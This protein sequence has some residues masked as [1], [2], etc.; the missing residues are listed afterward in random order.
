MKRFASTR[1]EK[2]ASQ[3]SAGPRAVQRR[4]HR[5]RRDPVRVHDPRLDREHDRDRAD[6]RDDPVDRDP[7]RAAAGGRVRRSTRVSH[8][9]SAL[10][11]AA[12]LAPPVVD[13]RVVAG[14]QHVRHR[15]AA[16]LGGPRVVRVLEPAVELL[17][18]ALLSPEP[19]RERAG[20]PP[21]DRVERAPS[22]AARR[23]RGRTGPIEIASVARCSTIRSSKPSKRAESSVSALLARE[24]LDDRLRRAGGPAASARPRGAPARRRRRPRARPRRRRRGGPCPA[25]PPYGSSST[26]PARSGVVSR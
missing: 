14:E 12:L 18:E 24:L 21:R 9:R 13:P 2:R 16:E 8:A 22:R 1:S 3:P 6:D 23:R 4:L 11:D 7:P 10:R 5:R 17:G 20:Q 15:P 26:W 25:P 19:S